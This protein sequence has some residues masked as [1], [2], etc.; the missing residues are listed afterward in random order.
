[1]VEWLMRTLNPPP[2]NR[3]ATNEVLAIGRIA[4]MA[5]YN[6]D[7]DPAWWVLLDKEDVSRV[8]AQGR[9]GY[10]DKRDRRGWGPYILRHGRGG[11]KA[12]MY[13]HRFLMDPPDHMWVDHANH[14]TLDNRKRNLRICLPV[15]NL[16]NRRNQ[17]GV[18]W[19]PELGVWR[20]QITAAFATEEEALEQRIAWEKALVKVGGWRLAGG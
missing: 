14:N 18:V 15:E 13:L 10:T 2:R 9:W 19:K 7:N 17:Q 12:P 3:R 4:A 6:R 16:R 1:M 11:G 20:A 5:V 8:L